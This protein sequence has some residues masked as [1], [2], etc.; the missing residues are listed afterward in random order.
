MIMNLICIQLVC[1]HY[2]VPLQHAVCLRA[3]L[4]AFAIL[5]L[6][7]VFC[8]ILGNQLLSLRNLIM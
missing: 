4:K 7:F 5:S 1:P 8:L 2:V 3:S 6:S